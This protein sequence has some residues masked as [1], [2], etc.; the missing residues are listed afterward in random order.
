M[1]AADDPSS[2]GNLVVELG[3]CTKCQVEEGLAAM[4]GVLLLG[5]TL[6]KLGYLT[7]HQLK[8]VLDYQDMERRPCN[9]V[10]MHAFVQQQH[11]GLVDDLRDI[12]EGMRALTK[13]INGKS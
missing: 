5:E 2:I 10:Q 12:T 13:K 6:V 3:Y 4:N 7:Q 9:T 1:S 8:W 11:H